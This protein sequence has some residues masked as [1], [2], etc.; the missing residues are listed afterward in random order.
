MSKEHDPYTPLLSELVDDLQPVPEGVDLSTY[1]IAQV[2]PDKLTAAM[3]KTKD[4][5]NTIM[6]W[7][8]SRRIYRL[9]ERIDRLRPTGYHPL[10]DE[11]KEQLEKYESEKEFADIVGGSYEDQRQLSYDIDNKRHSLSSIRRDMTVWG[12]AVLV[13]LV[14]SGST[15]VAKSYK[16]EGQKQDIA[17]LKKTNPERLA[18]IQKNE[19]ETI[20]DGKTVALGLGLFAGGGL[21]GLAVS[22]GLLD[23]RFNRHAQRKAKKIVKKALK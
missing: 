19:D 15:I 10:R 20:I 18:E 21:S 7:Q 14:M 17:W 12:S 1:L 11:L 22:L 8:N 9:N 13:G 3:S 6:Y 23:R 4:S 2:E 5:V 16:S